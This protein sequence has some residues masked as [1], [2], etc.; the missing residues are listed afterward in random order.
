MGKEET[1]LPRRRRDWGN[2]Q[3]KSSAPSPPDPLSPNPLRGGEGEYLER[4]RPREHLP[5]LRPPLNG[6]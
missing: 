4:E 5:P 1:F 2:T 3:R 6:L